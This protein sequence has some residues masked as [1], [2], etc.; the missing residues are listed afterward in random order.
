MGLDQN[1]SRT[2]KNNN[3]TRVEEEAD[4]MRRGV[5]STGDCTERATRAIA[6]AKRAM[7]RGCSSLGTGR[8]HATLEQMSETRVLNT[9]LS[10]LTCRRLQWFRP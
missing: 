4:L 10:A 5:P 8:P 3:R 1:E 9:V 6:S 2:Q 7:T